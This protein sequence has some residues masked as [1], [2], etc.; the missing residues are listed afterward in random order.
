MTVICFQPE[1][2]IQQKQSVK[3]SSHAG[4]SNLVNS[5]FKLLWHYIFLQMSWVVSVVMFIYNLSF[6]KKVIIY[7][8]R[9]SMG[10]SFLEEEKDKNILIFMAS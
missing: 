8:K 10:P 5:T 6:W 4:E 9:Q 2:H 1:I 3:L 7:P